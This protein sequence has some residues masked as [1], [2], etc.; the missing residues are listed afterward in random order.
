MNVAQNL[1]NILKDPNGAY[2]CTVD[3][4]DNWTQAWIPAVYYTAVEGDP[5][6]VNQWILAEIAKGTYTIGTYTPPPPPPPKTS[7]NTGTGTGPTVV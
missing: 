4:W 7:T 5:A 2:M 3:I 1:T 6:P